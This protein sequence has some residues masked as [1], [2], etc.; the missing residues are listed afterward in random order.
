MPDP[1]SD[2]QPDATTNH[3]PTPNTAPAL[4]ATGQAVG[5]QVETLDQTSPDTVQSW[6]S[7]SKRLVDTQA[8]LMPEPSS[9]AALMDMLRTEAVMKLT[10]STAGNHFLIV[11][12]MKLAGDDQLSHGPACPR[13][14]RST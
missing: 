12:S 13:H 9:E 14:G 2:N 1:S 10:G 6:K 11:Y 8:K 7:W 5:K 4:G 3:T